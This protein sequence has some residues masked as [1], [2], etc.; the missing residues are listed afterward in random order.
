MG[1]IINKVKHELQESFELR[2]K[3][4][5]ETILN[6]ELEIDDLDVSLPGRPCIT[7]HLHLATQ[8]LRRIYNIF[9]EMG[10]QVY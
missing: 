5:R 4:M 3:A 9:Q 2:Q 10:F 7:G 8:T 6:Q 1:K